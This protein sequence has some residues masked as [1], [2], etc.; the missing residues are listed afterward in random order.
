[1]KLKIVH[2]ADI[3]VQVRERNLRQS[4]EKCLR[5]IENKIST[6]G[7][8][9]YVIAGDLFEYALSND[10]EKS[11]MYE[12]L[13]TVLSMDCV[14]E[15][16]I[17]VGNHD[18]EKE[19]KRVEVLGSENPINTFYHL[20][21]ALDKRYSSKLN[22][23]KES[24]VHVSLACPEL[25]WIP[26][27][28]EDNM[29]IRGQE[30][31]LSA[32]VRYIS[33]FHDILKEYAI[34][35]KLPVTKSRL[36]SLVPIAE[37]PTE[38]ILAGDIHV[39]WECNQ[40]DKKFYYP[41]SPI[42][43]NYGEGTYFK[44]GKQYMTIP[45]AEKSVHMYEFDTDTKDFERKKDLVLS[46]YV[47]YHTLEVLPDA[48]YDNVVENVRAM[49]SANEVRFGKLQTF[50]KLKLSTLFV[51]HEMELH[52]LISTLASGHDSNINIEINYDKF[53]NTDTTTNVSKI[54]NEVAGE[55]PAQQ[56]SDG[57]EVSVELQEEASNLVLDNSKLRK[58]FLYVLDQRMQNVIK[59]NP[60]Q[61]E[62][63][64]NVYKEIVSIFDS[65]ITDC[66]GETKKT[67]IELLSIECNAFQILGAN[68]IHLDVPGITR[69][70]GTNGIGKTTLFS[71]LRWVIRG[72]LYEGM[73]KNTVKKNTLLV[74]NNKRPDVDDITVKLQLR[75]NKRVE[76]AI[77]RYASRT[78][79]RNVTDEQKSSLNWTEYVD[80]V[81][82]DVRL[83]VFSEKG[84][85][86]FTGDEAQ[87][88]IDRW[89]AQTPE[90]IMFLNHSKIQSILNTAPKELNQIVLDFI[91][92]DYLQALEDRLSDVK[93]NM[94]VTRPKRNRDAI[95]E[96][97]RQTKEQIAKTIQEIENCDKI[98]QE[99][100]QQM[101][102]A[103]SKIVDAQNRLQ[104]L[105]NIPEQITTTEQK[106][107]ETISAIDSFEKWE[108]KEISEWTETE[109]EKPNMETF[110]EEARVQNERLD[111][112]SNKLSEMEE[113]LTNN[114]RY[115]KNQYLSKLERIAQLREDNK[116]KIAAKTENN[117]SLTAECEELE[118]TIANG[119]CP[120][121]KRPYDNVTHIEENRKTLEEKRKL[122][123][124]N[125]SNIS[126]MKLVIS[127]CDDVETKLNA[128]IEK[129]TAT[130]IEELVETE[131]SE[132]LKKD[133]QALAANFADCSQQKKICEEIQNKL[134]GIV[135]ARTDANKNY[136]E[137]IEQ[138]ISR[139][140]KFFKEQTYI[141]GYNKTVMQHNEELIVLES[142]RKRYSEEL[143]IL[144]NEKLP[145]YKSVRDEQLAWSA[146]VE[147][148]RTERS[149]NTNNKHTY[150]LSKL[151]QEND[152]ENLN[153][154]MEAYLRYYVNSTIYS[155]YERLIKQDFK[156]IVFEYYRNYLN[157]NLNN[158]L[159]EQNFK[160]FWNNNNE[161]YMIDM[162]NGKC[163]Y[164]PVQ[165]T[166]G[167]E[168]SFLG[169]SLIYTMSCLNIKNHV[170][171]IFL[172]EIGGSLNNGKNLNYDAKNY[173][174]LF[175]NILSKF[176]N[177]SMFIID[178]TIQNMY[179]TV[180]LEVQP[181]ES[182][183]K[184]V[185]MN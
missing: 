134:L 60:G 129:L 84:E 143:E 9:I 100:V 185:K 37:F 94:T 55:E 40:F 28:L 70:T 109:P 136:T 112:E 2:T 170:S 8:N 137:A 42:Q 125:D 44:I 115:V 155:V 34:E 106:L 124:E 173:Q 146:K 63:I 25:A 91:G 24:G 167:M 107:N 178:H 183:S 67:S 11:V 57:G 172:D 123:E 65:E 114:I 1:M 41:G 29:S 141:A 175:V 10:A 32:D 154:E 46:D 36:D 142:D 77:T 64:K 76:V 16:V 59:E 104:T 43:R 174:E 164:T 130:G 176:T 6:T 89:F 33:L 177:I 56:V 168:I 66:V 85:R 86:E 22:Y 152:I 133:L 153:T 74:F 68:R 7:A 116:I 88:Y 71:M 45:A 166:S 162:R 171:H 5:E 157:N 103:G 21:R 4:Y 131:V 169:L 126:K 82:S 140:D 138:Y 156:N 158:L 30:L 132:S 27:S 95:L 93:E 87:R 62:F 31:E 53:I 148:L 147:E 38:F 151:Q 163:S 81:T 149:T 61:D 78:W 102:D 111:V 150:E 54:L 121:C 99:L 128:R 182:G 120:T 49:F 73:P 105:G 179:E 101:T 165:L 47:S 83:T 145:E 3:Q 79:K 75:I 90:T 12:H 80:K 51:E 14:K 180:T 97:I 15:V 17:M 23:L 139:K 113:S 160:L 48:T 50:F 108:E 184:Y 20:I 35:T 92:V 72:M 18:I 181:S 127:Q 144:K 39:N 118:T 122:I 26:F 52:K 159:E 117:N 58:L 135:E 13:S 98:D 19:K 96:A 161:L 110:D 69:I 119:I